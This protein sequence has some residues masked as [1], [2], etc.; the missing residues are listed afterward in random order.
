MNPKA[1]E[2][3]GRPQTI[4]EQDN[5]P[6][7][8][9]LVWLPGGPWALWRW[10]ALRGAGFPAKGVLDFSSPALSHSADE[11]IRLENEANLARRSAL[12]SLT[13][14]QKRAD[15]SRR[16]GL[17]KA[18]RQLRAGKA[19]SPLDPDC[20]ERNLVDAFKEMR[21]QIEAETVRF[22]SLYE[23]ESK[24]TSG[25][26]REVSRMDRFREAVIWQNRSAMHGSISA[27]LRM[28]ESDPSQ[29]AERR[30]REELIANYLQ[31]YCTK[32]ETIGFFGPVGWATLSPEGE[33]ITVKPGKSLLAARNVYLEVWCMNAFAQTLNENR[34]LLP[35]VAPRRMHYVY[36]EGATLHLPSRAPVRLLD[37]DAALL[38]ACDGERTAKEIAGEII[39]DRRLGL[40][41][42][43][44]V[45]G[46][47][48]QL[49]QK[50]L[51][52]WGF[53]ATLDLHPEESIQ[54]AIERVEDEALRRPALDALNELTAA[55]DEVARAAG[56]PERLDAA[57]SI[58]EA[59]FT[60]LT[61]SA[62]TRS[63][64][65]SYAART[66]AYEDC[67]RDVE[68]SFGPAILESLAPL[69]LLLTSARWFTYRTSLL[70]REELNR[71][72]DRA[73]KKSGS[74]RVDFATF[75]YQAHSLMFNERSNVVARAFDEFQ[76]RWESILPIST[77][78]RRVRLSV[79]QLR[80]AVL[81]TFAA[82]H[83]GWESAR[84][85][86]PDIMIS[87]SSA[88]A[89]SRGDYELVMGEV[90]VGINTLSIAV[91][92]GQHP[93]PEE[94]TRAV[95]LDRRKP[96]LIPIVPKKLLPAGSGRLL[97]SLAA[98]TDY[99]LDLSAEPSAADKSRTLSTGSLVIEEAEGG[100]VARTRDGLLEFELSEILG[101]AFTLQVANSFKL[102]R[103]RPHT[104]RITIDRLIVCREAWAVDPYE[105][106][107]A[108]EKSGADRFLAARRWARE[109]GMPR[110]VYAKTAV[111]NKP[112]YV[113]FDS[114]IYVDL[115]AKLVRRTCDLDDSDEQLF[116]T[117]M[118]PTLDRTWLEDAEG[119]R[120]TSEL[121][122]AALDLLS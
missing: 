107:F 77:G 3:T 50:G 113:D 23:A 92:P 104:P 84:Y 106:D 27:L 112:V 95:G 88:Q 60:R 64:G 5:K 109:N 51:I 105:L 74:R 26:I 117:E 43:Q 110:F 89:I 93:S 9:H 56:D 39:D 66:I 29:R 86:S 44:E 101:N 16:G 30:K 72:F 58:L 71:S 65:K 11:I 76:A 7:H 52:A 111:E 32:N 55:R 100:L 120:Y 69:S 121:R 35:W 115:L 45:Y 8:N 20:P 36:L 1:I 94:L 118:V 41:D 102:L 99:Y 96:Q 13:A 116:I 119:R 46:A 81:E 80:T 79:E 38:H 22:R 98:A 12:G 122:I 57:L 103:P 15:A 73:V 28:S 17:R 78:E 34:A 97:P 87:A 61:G 40:S 75:W 70:L 47:L 18:I 14:A 42:E 4:A 48:D 21:A 114:A 53:E 25:L 6:L 24:R 49:H 59:T 91:F 67:R 19:P 90:H 82:P 83:A 31:R 63:S 68:V 85:H 10:V 33:A 108:F 2:I 62:A 37:R 54:R